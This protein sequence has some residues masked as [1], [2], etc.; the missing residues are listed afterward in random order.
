MD[1]EIIILSGVSQTVKGKHHR[2]SLI[3]GN[4]KIDT[5]ELICRTETGSQALN[6]YLWSPKGTGVW[7]GRDGLVVGTG[8]CTVQYSE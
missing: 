3:H 6:T 7:G 8:I 5:N 4:K 1:L 2:I